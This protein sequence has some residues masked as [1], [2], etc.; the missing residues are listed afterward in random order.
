MA[1]TEF[2]AADECIIVLKGVVDRYKNASLTAEELE[3]A[4]DAGVFL[5]GFID[6]MTVLKGSD[7]LRLECH[8]HFFCDVG[9]PNSGFQCY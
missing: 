6:S 7:F 3:R 9:R 4:S 5:D 2:A 1:L 8:V